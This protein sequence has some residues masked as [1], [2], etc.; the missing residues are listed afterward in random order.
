MRVVAAASRKAREDYARAVSVRDIVAFFEERSKVKFLRFLLDHYVQTDI[1]WGLAL[2]AV[3]RPEEGETHIAAYCERFGVD[4]DDPV[5]SKARLTAAAH[6]AA[7]PD[8][9]P[10]R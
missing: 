6:H 10:T 1:A 4:P 5:L 9:T 8:E 7:E 2:I 3:G